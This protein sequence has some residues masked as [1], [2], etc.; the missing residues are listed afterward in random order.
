[1]IVAA[2]NLT[3]ANPLVTEALARLA[4]RPLQDLAQRCRPE[5]LDCPNCS[6]LE[7]GPAVFEWLFQE[8]GFPKWPDA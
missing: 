8:G 4:P 5:H 7:P 3:S 6:R 2:D 1:M